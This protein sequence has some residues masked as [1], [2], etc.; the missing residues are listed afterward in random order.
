MEDPAPVSANQLYASNGPRRFLTKAGKHFKASLVKAIL[1][2]TMLPDTGGAWSSWNEVVDL[3]YKTGCWVRLTITLYLP[4]VYNGS[5]ELGGSM[6]EPKKRKDGT[7]PKPQ[8]RSPYQKVDGSNYVK[9]IEDG[10]SEAV[11]IDDSAHLSVIMH[12]RES[13]DR[14]R[15]HILYEVLY[16]YGQDDRAGEST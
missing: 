3:V 10:V 9:L 2:I 14:P 16:T 8:P 15:V 5:W 13:P 12:K 7:T 6:T 1:A 4:R 11:G